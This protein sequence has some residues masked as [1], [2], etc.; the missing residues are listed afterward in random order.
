MDELGRK[1]RLLQIFGRGSEFAT[2]SLIG[3]DSDEPARLVGSNP[4]EQSSVDDRFDLLGLGI[5]AKLLQRVDLRLREIQ[6]VSSLCLGKLFDVSRPKLQTLEAREIRIIRKD[7]KGDRLLVDLVEQA[8]FASYDEF[9]GLSTRHH[10]RHGCDELAVVARLPRSGNDLSRARAL[11]V[12]F[13]EL[14]HA[15][16]VLEG[17]WVR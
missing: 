16:K 11:D 8:T 13:G 4:I 17:R 9:V 3:C 1:A 6:I 10:E 7:R 5:L 2:G 12:L 15:Q 14:H